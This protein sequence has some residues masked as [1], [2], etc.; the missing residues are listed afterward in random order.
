MG[1][2]GA[3][4]MVGICVF[5]FIHVLEKGSMSEHPVHRFYVENSLSLLP[6][7]YC[8]MWKV[9]DRKTGH[10]VEYFYEKEDAERAAS[11]YNNS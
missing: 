11:F 3:I 2:L 8:A 7:H 9:K 10:V 1:L 4:L 6:E 5:L